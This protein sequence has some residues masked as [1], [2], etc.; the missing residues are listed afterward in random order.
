MVSKMTFDCYCPDCK[1]YVGTWWHY[2]W[3]SG[4]ISMLYPCGPDNNYG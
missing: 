1:G 3:A 2:K 4:P